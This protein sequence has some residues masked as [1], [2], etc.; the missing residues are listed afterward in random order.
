MLRQLKHEILADARELQRQSTLPALDFHSYQEFF[1]SGQRLDFEK[2][3][4]ERRRQLVTF[5]L[6]YLLSEQQ[7]FQVELEN[8]MW[9]VCDEYSWAL[10]A[11]F[12]PQGET[13]APNSTVMVDLFAAETGQTL[14]EMASLFAATLAPAV[15]ARIQVEL[16]RRL[17]QPL[18][19]KEWAWEKLENNW[20]GVIAGSVGLAAL[21]ALPPQSAQQ[22]SIL[23][24]L[25]GALAAYLRSFGEDGA[26]EEGLGYWAYG[27]GYYIYFAAKYKQFIKMLV[28]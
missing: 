22:V 19:T 13:F 6:A 16:E 9:A 27:L 17:F 2:R 23:Q 1:I 25:E 7:E 26:C 12:E 3:Y 24:R 5:W 14:A 28:I 11:H 10:P 20:S 18:L 15:L 8:T 21:S 4:F